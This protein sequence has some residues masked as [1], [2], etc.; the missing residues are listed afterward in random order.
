M[1]LIPRI[2]LNGPISMVHF[3]TKNCNARC[4][5]CFIDFEDPRTFEGELSVEEISRVTQS[6]G[7]Q[8]RNV[9]LTGGEPFL[10]KDLFDIAR[11]YLD[12]TGIRSVYITTNGYFTDRTKDFLD[13]YLTSGYD[14]EHTLFF[15]ISVDDHPEAH[16]RNR[17]INGLFERA[18]QTLHLLEEY[19]DR[20]VYANVNLT[21]IPANYRQMGEIYEYLIEKEGVR[22]FTTTIIREE[23][24]A[25]IPPL[26]REGLYA[27]YR[28]L[29]QRIKRDILSRRIRGFDG[30]RLGDLVNAKNILMHEQI[31]RTFATGKFISTCYAGEVFLVLEA[32]G[33]VRPCEVLPTVIGNVRKSGYDLSSIWKSE[34]ALEARRFIVETDCHCTYECAWSL[35]TLTDARYYPQLFTNLLQLKS[36]KVE[37]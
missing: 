24:V 29:N 6:M 12:N 8:L 31:E 36:R 1:K 5:H 13:R 23:G 14:K 27:A 26:L 16:D 3:V 35:N 32:N 17:K 15:S 10:R 25:T 22:S 20:C 30:S 34:D 7:W 2:L 18:M 4:S 11:C 33:D 37:S 28:D 21:I 9:N 19:R